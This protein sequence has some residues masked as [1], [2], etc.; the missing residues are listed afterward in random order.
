MDCGLHVHVRLSMK[1]IGHDCEP[2]KNGSAEPFAV[3]RWANLSVPKKQ[4]IK[5]GCRTDMANVGKLNSRLLWQWTRLVYASSRHK[6]R[7]KNLFVKYIT[8]Q[9]INSKN[10]PMVG[11]Q[12]KIAHQ[13]WP[14][15]THKHNKL[16]CIISYDRKIKK[17]GH[18]RSVTPL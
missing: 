15:L 17:K 3:W 4:L 2:C 6:K 9:K 10:S 12:K 18:I 5:P 1:C 8:K 7:D 11:C 14:T 16:T 13:C